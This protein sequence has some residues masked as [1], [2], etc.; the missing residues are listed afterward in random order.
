[1]HSSEPY[2]KG[3]V[4][5]SEDNALD[6]SSKVTREISASVEKADLFIL[7][8]GLVEVWFNRNRYKPSW[9]SEKRVVKVVVDPEMKFPDVDR[10]NNTWSWPRP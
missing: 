9:P 6:L 10:S 5:D 8:L 2:R 3:I 1:M 4:A 7:T